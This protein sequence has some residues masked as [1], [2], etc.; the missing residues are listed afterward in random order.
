MVLPAPGS[1]SATRALSL[2]PARAGRRCRSRTST[3]AGAPT[4]SRGAR[5]ASAWPA[6]DAARGR[7]RD[8]AVVQPLLPARSR[9]SPTL[10]SDRSFGEA[11]T[12]CAGSRAP[13]GRGRQRRSSA[14][15]A[16]DAGRKIRAKELTQQRS[17]RAGSR[18]WQWGAA[19]GTG[20]VR[21]EN[22]SGRARY[23]PLSWAPR[24]GVPRGEWRQAERFKTDAVRSASSTTRGIGGRAGSRPR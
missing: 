24:A 9:A 16:P 10:D 15:P 12:C 4:S 3:E 7:R 1:S 17:R 11:S 18:L 5:I 22:R 23:W 14:R 6:S 13:K 21:K 19:A 8:F 20:L 2:H